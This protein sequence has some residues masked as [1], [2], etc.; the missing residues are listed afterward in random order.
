MELFSRATTPISQ[1]TA[2][3]HNV[4][5]EE[6][7]QKQVDLHHPPSQAPD[8]STRWQQI[9]RENALLRHQASI[10][11]GPCSTTGDQTSH[12]NLRQQFQ[13]FVTE[14]RDSLRPTIRQTPSFPHLPSNTDHRVERYHSTPAQT[15]YTGHLAGCREVWFSAAS[16]MPPG[17]G[18][19]LAAD[20]SHLSVSHWLE[21]QSSYPQ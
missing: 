10:I 18:D 1:G 15:Q 12:A 21:G 20:L 16:E 13:D 3:E 5:K 2:P 11:P 9:N 8:L 17:P 6:W 19:V 14:S 4:L 7:E